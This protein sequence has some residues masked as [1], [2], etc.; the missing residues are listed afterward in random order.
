MYIN[1]TPLSLR[2]KWRNSDILQISNR[3]DGSSVSSPFFDAALPGV[4]DEDVAETIYNAITEEIDNIV[5]TANPDA[6]ALLQA[7]LLAG[8]DGT[9]LS[10]PEVM[11]L[12]LGAFPILHCL[13][14]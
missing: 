10:V 11:K 14:E 5:A 9:S 4:A 12:T 1:R 6:T 13:F 7:L 3:Q 2:A 8:V